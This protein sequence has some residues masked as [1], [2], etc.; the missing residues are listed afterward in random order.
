M[1]VIAG[2]DRIAALDTDLAAMLASTVSP[3]VADFVLAN[4]PRHSETFAA[5]V[6]AIVLCADIAG[7]SVAGAALTRS[8]ERGAEELR[9]IVSTVFGRV[10]G[11]PAGRSCSSPA[12][13]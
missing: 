9:S 13:R 10:T 2:S 3:L 1:G 5:A 12:M 6:P 7:F 4:A 8:D 11:K